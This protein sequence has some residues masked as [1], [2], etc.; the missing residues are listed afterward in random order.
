MQSRGAAVH[1][2]VTVLFAALLLTLAAASLARAVIYTTAI[3]SA[4]VPSAYGTKSNP[5]QGLF[6][7]CLSSI[8]ASA[9]ETD[10]MA[11]TIRTNAMANYVADILGRGTYYLAGYYDAATDGWYWI[12]GI[13][14]TRTQFGQGPS[15]AAVNNI[16]ALNWISGYPKMEF[17]NTV[18]K[19]KFLV[20]DG[21]QKGWKNVAGTATYDGVAC[22]SQDNLV[23]FRNEK[24]KFPWWGILIIVLGSVV[25]IAV[26]VTIVVVCCC[27]CK[28]KP[29]KSGTD[30]D[31]SIS[32]DEDSVTDESSTNK[33]F[34]LGRSE[35]SS[36]TSS[37][38]SMASKQSSAS[39]TTESYSYSSYSD[40]DSDVSSTVSSDD[41]VSCSADSRRSPR[42]RRNAADSDSKSS[43][44]S[45]ETF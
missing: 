3:S 15:C 16:L 19:L 25:I 32:V 43:S 10:R 41:H 26:V 36:C 28:K 14:A 4:Y 21:A 44:S 39:E 31:D 9:T 30:S 24:K 17:G 1:T 33:S 42:S 13:S 35:A 5:L 18:G 2:T 7:V 45:S 29:E 11:L 38:S 34:I 40:T 12:D 37:P 8:N 27:C 20:Y 23:T 6:E 22:E